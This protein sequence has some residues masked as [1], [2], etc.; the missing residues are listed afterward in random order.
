MGKGKKDK[1]KG[2]KDEP[3]GLKLPKPVKKAGKAAIKAASSPAVSEA[4]AAALLAAAAAL[5]DGKTIRDGAKAAG[6]AATDAVDEATR[7]MTGLASSL[8]AIAID[9]ARKT[10]DAWAADEDG[11]KRKGGGG[12]GGKPG[13]PAKASAKAAPASAKPRKGPARK[14]D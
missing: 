13:K 11:P 12:G 14:D 4:V 9:V 7:D 10:I 2:R 5:R 1:K 3:A 8:R 6:V